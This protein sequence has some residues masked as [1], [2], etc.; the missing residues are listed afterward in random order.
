MCYS[1][2]MI[3]DKSPVLYACSPHHIIT[4]A[5]TERESIVTF[6]IYY[7]YRSHQPLQMI[8]FWVFTVYSVICCFQY[9]EG[10]YCH[11]HQSDWFRWVCPLELCFHKPRRLLNSWELLSAFIIIAETSLTVWC[12][13]GSWIV[14]GSCTHLR[15]NWVNCFLHWL[16]GV[17]YN[18]LV[19]LYSNC[20]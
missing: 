19:I 4:S 13:A 12:D 3:K 18:S 16:G 11:H 17:A 1:V 2:L 8:I 15:N 9:F 7:L 20:P 6:S 14:T 5:I 10:I